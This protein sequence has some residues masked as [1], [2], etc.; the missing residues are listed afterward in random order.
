MIFQLMFGFETLNTGPSTP[1]A[2]SQNLTKWSRKWSRR[3]KI[4]FTAQEDQKG[5]VSLAQC[6]RRSVHTLTS[7]FFKD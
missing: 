6:C 4:H 2:F 7:V 5:F 1:D 3:G